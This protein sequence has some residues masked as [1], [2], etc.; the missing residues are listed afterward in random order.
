MVDQQVID[1]ST[2]AA[3]KRLIEFA[4]FGLLERIHF[5]VELCGE[6]LSLPDEVC[7]H[8]IVFIRYY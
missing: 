8:V 5:S 2:R 3:Q 6:D 1:F 4:H 7:G